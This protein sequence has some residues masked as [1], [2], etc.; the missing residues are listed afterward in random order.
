MEATRPQI[1]PEH[2]IIG[3]KALT[4]LANLVVS[5]CT[6]CH[7]QWIHVSQITTPAHDSTEFEFACHQGHS[8]KWNSEHNEL[9]I[10]EP[11]QEPE[12]EVLEVDHAAHDEEPNGPFSGATT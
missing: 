10:L 12:S 8:I 3:L 4:N 5:S 9:I 6:E 1:P 11:P 7:G 2:T